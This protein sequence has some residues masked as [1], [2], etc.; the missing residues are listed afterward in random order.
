MKINFGTKR[1]IELLAP[2]R[3]P[4]WSQ[5]DGRPGKSIGIRKTDNG[6]FWLARAAGANGKKYVQVSLNSTTFSDA[7]NEANEA[8]FDPL[9]SGVTFS[10][11]TVQEMFAD[12]A[13][14]VAKS[15]THK[16][17]LNSL[18]NLASVKLRDLKKA[19]IVAWVESDALLLGHNGKPRSR[20]TIKRMIAPVRAALNMAM[21]K[22]LLRDGNWR[23]GFSTRYIEVESDHEARQ[24]VRRYLTPDER[25]AII[26]SARPD[27]QGWLT[28]CAN[29]PLRPGDWND[30]RVEHFDP[31]GGTFF[32]ESKN[33]P[34]H[35]KLSGQMVGMLK[36]C[37]KSK[38]PKALVFTRQHD[39]STMWRSIN[40]NE[41]VKDAAAKAGINGSVV[42][43]DFRHSV[44]TDL[45]EAGLSIMQTAKLAGTSALMIEKHYSK[46]LADRQETYL[47]RIAI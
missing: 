36:D 32:V 13:E 42:L 25:R 46:V 35:I 23:L 17:I 8:L 11:I 26:A 31:V 21:H 38:T 10:D 34:R 29:I 5:I 4:Y 1:S 16:T 9:E 12:Y 41:I 7:I 22:D 43:Y 40:W 20:E 24:E 15:P 18:G 44:I 3:E 28:L 37:C 33:H 47:D 39:G 27:A 45:L 6:I 19:H 2:R 30:R 14:T